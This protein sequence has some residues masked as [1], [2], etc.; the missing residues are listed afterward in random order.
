MAIEYVKIR[1]YRSIETLDLTLGNLNALI[2]GNNAGKSNILR[3]VDL[4]IGGVWPSHPFDDRDYYCLDGTRTISITVMF[5]APLACDADVRGFCLSFDSIHG[6]EFVPVDATETPCIWPGGRPKRVSNVMR[7]E[8]PLLYIDLDRLAERQLRSTQ[9]TLYGRMLREIEKSVPPGDRAAF[10]QAVQVALDTHLRPHLEHAQTVIDAL[11]QRQTGLQIDLDFRAV[12]PL[13][14]LKGVRPFVKDGSLM[15]DPEDVGAGV[16]SALT[17][18]VAR[19]YTEIVN[20]P[21]TLAIEEPEL[22]LHPHGCRHFYRLLRE[23]A[24][25]GLQV[26]YTTHSRSFVSAGDFDDLYIVRKATTT[27]TTVTEGRTYAPPGGVNALR[28]QSKFNERLNEAFFASAV[29]LVEGDP[30]EIACRCALEHLTLDLDRQS[31]SVLSVGGKDEIG[32][33][34]QL[35][36]ALGIPT[37]ALVD[38]DPGN[39]NSAA[40]Q[41]SIVAIVGPNRVFLQRPDLEGLFALATKPSRLRAMTIFPAWF[42]NGANVTPQVYVDLC[43]QVIMLSSPPATP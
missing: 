37:F 30:D 28:L 39:P 15:S 35:L 6:V 10:A 25:Q 11:V 9:W 29:V 14:V 34:A 31:I 22:Y 36:L 43:A 27:G 32:P 5:T 4:V 40:T 13:E 8:V 26:I 19:A 2:G 12:D 16:Q 18:A 1:N 41:A 24:G 21:L 17:V 33:I 3:A 20:E 23:I 38:E 7:A 42:A